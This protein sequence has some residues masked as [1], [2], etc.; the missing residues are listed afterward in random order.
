MVTDF[1]YLTQATQFDSFDGTSLPSHV[2]RK[3][4]R[5]PA[6]AFSRL[7][8]TTTY[9]L[10]PLAIHNRS[11]YIYLQGLVP[12]EQQVIAGATNSFAYH[13]IKHL[14]RSRDEGESR[15]MPRKGVPV[16]SCSRVASGIT[17]WNQCSLD[18]SGMNSLLQL[19]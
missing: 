17:G 3:K 6:R 16:T 11:S 10:L 8:T 4:P 13:D 15:S 7:L 1:L 18:K 9:I 12:A 5:N 14:R 2:T 19:W